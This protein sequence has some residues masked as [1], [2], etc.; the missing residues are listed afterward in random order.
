MHIYRLSSHTFHLLITIVSYNYRK[1]NT[2]WV[3][4]ELLMKIQVII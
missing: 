3:I 4:P 2:N 1:G